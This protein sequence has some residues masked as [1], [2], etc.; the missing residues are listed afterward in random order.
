M[1]RCILEFD[2]LWLDGM[3]LVACVYGVG[4]EGLNRRRMIDTSLYYH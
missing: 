1:P 4:G 3:G 2:V